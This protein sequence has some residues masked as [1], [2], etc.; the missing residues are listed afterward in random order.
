V[1]GVGTFLGRA[2][3]SGELIAA[4]TGSVRLVRARTVQGRLSLWCFEI[5]EATPARDPDEDV[6]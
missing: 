5:V 1:R 6:L 3:R 2:A 4:P